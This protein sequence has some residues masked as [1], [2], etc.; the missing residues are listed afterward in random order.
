MFGASPFGEFDTHGSCGQMK[1]T[2]SVCQ[3]QKIPLSRLALTRESALYSTLDEFRL[4]GKVEGRFSPGRAE[5]ARTTGPIGTE[6]F[7]RGSDYSKDACES[8]RLGFQP[9]QRDVPL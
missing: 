4:V 1:D 9:H 3:G 5:C 2:K 8:A 7:V 6:Y